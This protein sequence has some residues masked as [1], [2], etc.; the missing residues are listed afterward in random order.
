VSQANSK[1]QAEI[2]AFASYLIIADCLLGL[3]FYP[4]DWG[5]TFFFIFF[6]FG[7]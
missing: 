5:S 1:K 7:L 3:L 2:R 4:E 6:L